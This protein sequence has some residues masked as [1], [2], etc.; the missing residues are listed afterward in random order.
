MFTVAAIETFHGKPVAEVHLI[1]SAPVMISTS[2]VVHSMHFESAITEAR[3]IGPADPRPLP[4][5]GVTFP[6]T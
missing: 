2:I 5:S 1:T 6:S 3:Y 4:R